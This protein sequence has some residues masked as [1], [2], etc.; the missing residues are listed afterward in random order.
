MNEAFFKLAAEKARSLAF[1]TL[2]LLLADRDAAYERL[3]LDNLEQLKR[4]RA[5][6]EGI[7]VQQIE[8]EVTRGS[9][10]Y[11]PSPELLAAHQASLRQ[12]VESAASDAELLTLAMQLEKSERESQKHWLTWKKT[13]PENKPIHQSQVDFLDE[14]RR[15]LVTYAEAQKISLPQ[16]L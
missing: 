3:K 9:A 5:A 8:R 10:P 14:N 7:P 4:N 13:P 12:C 2:M 6:R 15:L 11:A 16:G 1:R